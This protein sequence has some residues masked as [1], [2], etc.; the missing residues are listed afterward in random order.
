RAARL[1]QQHAGSQSGAA[2]GVTIDVDK[3]VPA[4]GGLGGGSSDAA[5][6]LMA[7]NRLW[8]CGLSREALQALGL[9]LGADVPVF[10]FG[11]SAFA[12]GVGEALQPCPV[13]PAS[14][15]LIV[16]TISVATAT[17]FGYKDLTRD[18][19]PVIMHDF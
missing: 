10:I 11:Q 1:L 18:T 3:I 5:S 8:G 9:S 15:L 4:G 19:K 13:P 16:P 17:V 7:L 12:Q 14:Y 6:T 2:A